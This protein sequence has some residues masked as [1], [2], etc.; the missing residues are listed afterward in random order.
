MSGEEILKNIEDSIK[1]YFHFDRIKFSSFAMASFAVMRDTFPTQ[2]NFLLVDVGGEVTDISII[3]KN[4]LEGS[5]SYPL[6]INFL[7][8]RTSSERGLSLDEASSLISLYNSGHAE[9]SVDKKMSVIITK[10]RQEW[11]TKFQDAL[12]NLSNDI[13]IPATVYLAVEGGFADFFS[14]TIKTE[15]LNQYSLTESKF[16]I[17]TLSPELFHESVVF[18][19][20]TIRD[21]YLIIDSNY[22]NRYLIKS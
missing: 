8:R 18:G 21:P 1:K 2:D 19:E 13:S 15:Q 20:N 3:K 16:E 5:V 7:S 17:F 6:G 22:I 12:A 9:A 10:L 14:A 11:L 4:V